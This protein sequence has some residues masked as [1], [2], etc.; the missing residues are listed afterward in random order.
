MV[1]RAEVA[2]DGW[3]VTDLRQYRILADHIPPRPWGYWDQIRCDVHEP[4]IVWMWVAGVG[5]TAAGVSLAAAAA[6]TG[7]WL[8][9][10][11]GLLVLGGL[12]P[13]V[14]WVYLAC[15]VVRAIRTHPVATAV[16]DGFAP[17]PV[18]PSI[19]AVGRATRPSGEPVDV[20]IEWP[21]AREIERAGIPAEIWFIDDPAADYRSVFAV[22]PRSAR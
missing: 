12:V 20:G 6:V 21:L 3:I 7:Q 19:T 11:G 17:H 9:L 13:L 1:L 10:P 15:G 18:A 8:L 16:V 22:R 5:L 14:L 2:P 4:K